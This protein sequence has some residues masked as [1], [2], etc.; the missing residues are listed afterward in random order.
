MPA[1]CLAVPQVTARVQA[2]CEW[3]RGN[4]EYRIGSTNATDSARSLHATGRCLPGL[5]APGGDFC[6]AL[7]IPARLVSGYATFDEPPPDFHAVLR[8]I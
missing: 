2:I 5:C 4:N 7:N 1:S 6:R 8:L 3:V